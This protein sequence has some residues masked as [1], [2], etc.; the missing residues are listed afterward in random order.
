MLVSSTRHKA[1]CI[2]AKVATALMA[3][4]QGC[5]V[6]QHPHITNCLPSQH[7]ACSPE[8]RRLVHEGLSQGFASLVLQRTHILP[9]TL[10]EGHASGVKHVPVGIVALGFK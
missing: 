1:L 9:R 7:T 3:L 4:W 10:Q 5:Y 6:R 8:S 2:S